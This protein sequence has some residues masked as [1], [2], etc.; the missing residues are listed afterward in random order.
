MRRFGRTRAVA[1]AV[2]SLALMA[3]G[4][5]PSKADPGPP[6]W[7]SNSCTTAFSRNMQ[8]TGP[9]MTSYYTLCTYV[10]QT[11]DGYLEYTGDSVNA[12]NA[13]Y[14]IHADIDT[15]GDYLT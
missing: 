9:Y 5:A 11:T 10:P 4:V 3:V 15:C 6:S 12:P 13:Y 7:P 8:D 1:V 2:C 14:C